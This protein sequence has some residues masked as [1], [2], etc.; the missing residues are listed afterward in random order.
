MMPLPDPTFFVNRTDDPTPTSPISS[1]CNN[2]S[3]SDNSSSCSLREA[4]IKANGIVG[5]DTIMLAAA[6]YTLSIP[7]N[8]LDHSSSATG[9]LEVQDSLNIVGAVDGG[10]NPASIVQ[11]G[12]TQGTGVDKVFS[13]NQDIDSFTDATV[14]IS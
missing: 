5:T 1:A 13:F 9:T 2:V 6:T 3:A 4:I 8:P 14:G 7:R 11:G 10:G 12:L